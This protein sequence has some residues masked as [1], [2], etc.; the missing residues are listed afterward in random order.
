MN[1]PDEL[2]WEASCVCGEGI[3]YLHATPN[4]LSIDGVTSEVD[5]WCYLCD[6]CGYEFATGECVDFNAKIARE[7][8]RRIL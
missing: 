6:T 5:C 7:F 2:P 8:Y 1:G 4:T 3:G